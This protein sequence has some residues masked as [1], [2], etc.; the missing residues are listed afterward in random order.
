M[1]NKS[2]F[3]GAIFRSDEMLLLPCLGAPTM[4]WFGKVQDPGN[5][6]CKYPV[7]FGQAVFRREI[8]DSLER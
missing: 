1:L 8:R 5:P 7:R 4:F 3:C 2:E 6:V